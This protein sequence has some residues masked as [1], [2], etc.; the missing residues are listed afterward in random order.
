MNMISERSFGPASAGGAVR[1]ILPV[2]ILM[3][4]VG[5]FAA[6]RATRTQPEPL[7]SS[8]KA[9]A[10][11]T[12][13]VALESVSPNLRLFGR[14]ESPTSAHLTAG[15]AADVVE[16][17]VLEGERVEKGQE[18]IR[19]DDSEV[20]LLLAQYEAE[21]RDIQAQI[22]L[23]VKKHE[24]NQKALAHERELLALARKEVERAKQLASTNVGSQSQID[25]AQQAVE[26]QILAVDNRTLA[27]RQ[28]ESIRAQLESRLMRAT[29]VRDRALLDLERTRITAPFG[30]RATRV[31]VAAGDRVKVGD[32][33]VSL[34]DSS[35]LEIRAQVPTRH[36][37]GIRQALEGGAPP[38]AH[39]V[40]DGIRLEAVLNRISGEVRPGSGG[41]DALFRVTTPSP[42]LPLG[43]TV[44]LVVDLPP[45]ANAVQV[46]LEAIYGTDRIYVLD[47]DRMRSLNVERV[48]ELNRP[49]E[50]SRV[51]IRSDQLEE[52]QQ[53][54]V[55]HLPNA[56]DGLRVRVVDG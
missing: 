35:R 44:E 36:L 23:E 8:E 10:V 24:N 21:I 56:I 33:L 53:V 19:L 46:P 49:G 5:A 29:A 43:R 17:F 6:L 41:A 22:E 4:G 14:V 42:W 27:I 45:V 13:R 55:T 18:L 50:E 25:A 15:I 31:Q 54:I 11:V 47:G 20:K 12:Q 32:P 37:P 2:L 39:S 28:H 26:R 48:G 30:G 34:Y 40:V 38:R 51:L 52:G 1:V 9:W 16:V 7:E 3:F